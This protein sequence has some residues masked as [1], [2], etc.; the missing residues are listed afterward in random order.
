MCL[1]VQVLEEVCQ[2]SHFI[3]R[4]QIRSLIR[5]DIMMIFIVELDLSL[6]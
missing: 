2:I 1:C 5:I 4:N 3:G 6:L